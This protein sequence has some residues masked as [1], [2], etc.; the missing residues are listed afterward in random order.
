MAPPSSKPVQSLVYCSRR[1]ILFPR[2]TTLYILC[3]TLGPST[4]GFYFNYTTRPCF[5]RFLPQT[6]FSGPP[7]KIPVATACHPSRLKYFK[8]TTLPQQFSPPG[9][10]YSALSP[11][12][13]QRKHRHDSEL[14]HHQQPAC[15]PPTIPNPSTGTNI[16]WSTATT[17]ATDA[18]ASPQFPKT[19]SHTTP[20]YNM[21]IFSHIRKSRQQAKEHNA[22]VAE[23]KRR[24]SAVLPY[25]HVPTHA[26]SDAIACAPPSWREQADRPRIVEHN[27]RRSAMAAAGYS[28]NM[29]GAP[30]VSSSLSYVSYPSGDATPVVRMP[31]AQSYNNIYPYQ[32]N[33]DVIYS[34]P[35]A[36]MSQPSSWKGK[37]VYRGMYDTS[38]SSAPSKGSS[39][40]VS[41]KLLA[42]A[43]S[44]YR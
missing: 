38:S 16:L 43:H 1:G 31:R 18:A 17:N 37:D 27:R 39:R 44:L 9:N 25:K 21:S 4:A 36:S 26:A 41:M 8:Q 13:L 19:P 33:R 12:F 22:K 15:C 3:Q 10:F 34:M 20:R 32:G 28:M 42:T 14:P 29:P 7:A 2:H 30:R 6:P 11:R 23:Q 24:E 5:S 35:D 40:A